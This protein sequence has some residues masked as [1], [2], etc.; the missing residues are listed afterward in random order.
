MQSVLARVLATASWANAFVSM[1]L[2]V[3]RASVV[4]ARQNAQSANRKK[5]EALTP[6]PPPILSI[7]SGTC[8]NDCSGQ[9]IC[10]TLREVAAGALSRTAVGSS[11]GSLLFSGVRTP[12]DYTLWDADKHQ[13]CVCD[14]GF[15]GVD[16]SQRICPRSDDPLTPSTPRWCGGKVCSYEVQSFRLSSAGDTTFKLQFTDTRNNTNMAYATVNTITNPPG[17][18]PLDQ[19]ATMIAGAS[20]NAGIIMAA[21]RNIPGGSMQLVEVS[22][23]DNSLDNGSLQRSFEITYIGFSGAQY[24]IVVTSISGQGAVEL[25]PSIVTVGNYEDIECSGRG[26]CDSGAGLCKC[27]LCLRESLVE[28]TSAYPPPSTPPPLPSLQALL[29]I[30]GWRASTRTHLRPT[31]PNKHIYTSFNYDFISPTLP[32]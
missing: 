8:P 17:T 32:A 12:F 28:A 19:R 20:S 23:V 5:C 10:R 11:G 21:L 4:S 1:G 15:S 6:H 30:T 22:A 9:G 2:R 3:H 25:S 14:A 31:P 27:K 7:P 13:M 24:P 29:V 26:L 16:C 18:V